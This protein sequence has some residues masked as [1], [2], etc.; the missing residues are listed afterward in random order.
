MGRTRSR[1][2]AAPCTQAHTIARIASI[3]NALRHSSSPGQANQTISQLTEKFINFDAF[4]SGN[5]CSS[6]CSLA[7]LFGIDKTSE[8]LAPQKSSEHENGLFHLE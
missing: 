1:A 5:H 6:V 8:T 7:I 2:T 4:P 3:A